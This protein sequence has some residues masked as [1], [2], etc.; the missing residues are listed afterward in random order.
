MTA[1]ENRFGDMDPETFR[2][3]GYRVVD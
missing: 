1:P 2:R 3:E